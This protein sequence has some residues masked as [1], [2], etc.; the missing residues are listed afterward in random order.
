MASP[1]G[2]FL[3][4][5]FRV[6]ICRLHCIFK[7]K[8]KKILKNLTKSICIANKRV[9]NCYPELNQRKETTE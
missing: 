8:I 7:L 4:V 5:A 9:L 1:M 2:S 3:G 6:T